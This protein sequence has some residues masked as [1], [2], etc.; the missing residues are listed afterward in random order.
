[1]NRMIWAGLLAAAYAVPAHAQQFVDCSSDGGRV[2][3]CGADTRGGVSLESQ[4]SRSG[5]YFNDTWGY[6]RDSVWVSNGCRA[7]FRLGMAMPYGQRGRETHSNGSNRG[8]AVAA[9][10]ILGAAAIA[11]SQQKHDTQDTRY[12]AMANDAWRN[13]AGGSQA[14]YE[15]E[16]RNGCDAARKGGR[17]SDYASE[18]W[19]TGFHDCR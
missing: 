1:M 17:Y 11:A 8:A 13:R 6:D 7:R 18:G 10:A 3:R 16:Y 9:I 5:C 19:R 14:E 2:N 15:S 12:K 4:Y